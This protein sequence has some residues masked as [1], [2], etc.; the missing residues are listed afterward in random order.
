MK[1][2]VQEK[3]KANIKETLFSFKAFDLIK[4]DQEPDEAVS[5]IM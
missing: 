5:C 3:K 4:K 1:N 2:T